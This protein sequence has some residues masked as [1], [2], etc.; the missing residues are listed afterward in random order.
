MKNILFSK[1]I[2]D[3]F[4]DNNYTIMKPAN[5]VNDRDTVFYSAGIQP[6]LSEYLNHNLEEKQDIFVAQPVIRTQYQNS[7]GEGTSLAFINATTSKFNLSEEDYKK[8]VNDWLEFFYELG[9]DKRKFS[10]RS[11]F[12]RGKWDEMELSGKR[13]FYYY[14]DL[15]VGDTTFFTDVANENIET[16]C[17]LGFGLERLRWSTNKDKSYYDLYNESRNISPQEKALMSA[18][19]LLNVCKVKPSNKSYGYRARSFSKKLAELLES[20]K[21]IEED[22]DYIN[23]CIKYWEEWQQT[24]NISDFNQIEKEYERN[25]NHNIIE[26]LANEGYNV[27][28]ININISWEEMQKRLRS[29]A[30]P[31]ERIKQII[32]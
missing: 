8:L 11:D 15:E 32:R 7:L 30:V 23:Q 6:I 24:P 13:T 9:L 28:G 29:S 17:D 26:E 12:Y 18:L 20:K 3:Y 4:K 16:M 5:I 1:D 27:R 21:L 22:V 19:A 10:T 2:Y 31:K 14:D 25:C